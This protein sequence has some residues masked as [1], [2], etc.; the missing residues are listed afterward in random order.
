[1]V[2][3]GFS[4]NSIVLRNFQPISMNGIDYD[5][6]EYL[7]NVRV[8]NL[9]KEKIQIDMILDRDRIREMKNLKVLIDGESLAVDSE[10]VKDLS[11]LIY[12]SIMDMAFIYLP[13]ACTTGTRAFL[14]LAGGATVDILH[15]NPHT[16]DSCP[17]GVEVTP[18]DQKDTKKGSH[19]SI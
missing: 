13:G 10:L 18:L 5:L 15:D 19:S 1:M 2:L 11:S 8:A 7:L 6:T 3:E 4:D 9:L 16:C 17:P 14:P 12:D